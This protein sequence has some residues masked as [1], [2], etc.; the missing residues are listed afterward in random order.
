MTIPA[1]RRILHAVG[2]LD[3]GGIETWL[4][5]LLRRADRQRLQLDFLVHSP[6]PG[7]YDDDVRAL[8]GTIHR[9]P[10]VA[11]P[12]RYAAAFARIVR[13]TGPYDIVHSHV[14]HFSGYVLRLAARAGI[15]GR[16]AHSH[17]DTAA[18]DPRANPAR[19]GYLALMRRWLGR[20]ATH[21]LAASRRSATALYGQRS[22][23]DPRVR[24]L[25]CGVALEPFAAPVDRGA[26][27]AALGL[28]AGDFVVGHVGRFAEQKN[29]PFL[30]AIFAAIAAREPRARLLLVGDGPLRPAIARHVASAGLADNVVFTGSRPDVPALMR[31]AMDAFV[32]PS[33]HEGL[34]L[35]GVEAQAAG[36]PVILSDALTE[37]VAIVPPLIH[38]LS[39]ARPAADW[40]E[41]LLRF[42]DAPPAIEQ[43]A[44][45]R[46][47]ER[48]SFNIDASLHA[49]E[50]VYASI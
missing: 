36:L 24:V 10:H 35:V 18:L 23:A 7:V 49:L 40:A 3:R 17:S 44:A 43:R 28:A 34:A 4:L 15:R 2:V 42:K 46:L 13:D 38:R 31:G 33:L 5:H 26:I 48:S 21:C 32:L 39:L 50:R 47:V 12:W 9:C 27:R 19:R 14:H 11:H 29:H 22:S 8:G 37:E 6:H 45:L 20:Y 41:L 30:I 1:Q 25:H 16:I